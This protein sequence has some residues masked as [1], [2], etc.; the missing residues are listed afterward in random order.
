M[1]ESRGGRDWRHRAW[2][3]AE[4]ALLVDDPACVRTTELAVAEADPAVM[5]AV[6]TDDVMERLEPKVRRLI[7]ARANAGDEKGV[8][9]ALEDTLRVVVRDEP[10]ARFVAAVPPNPLRRHRN[11]YLV[12]GVL[13]ERID[14]DAV[15]LSR[16]RVYQ[17]ITITLLRWGEARF[18]ALLAWWDG[19]RRRARR[20]AARRAE[21]RWRREHA[22]EAREP[23]PPPLAPYILPARMH[24]AGTWLAN[25]ARE[26]VPNPHEWLRILSSVRPVIGAPVGPR[27]LPPPWPVVHRLLEGNT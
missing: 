6:P 13:H 4:L 5:V 8:W 26:E 12:Y 2:R 25:A 19:E 10:L 21:R 17:L 11:A 24:G 18:R 20:V 14:L 3:E 15:T 9:H 23:A 22:R 7:H 16:G 27:P 1:S